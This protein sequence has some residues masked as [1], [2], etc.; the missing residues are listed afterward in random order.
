[1]GLISRVSSRTY[2]LD[3]MTSK[4]IFSDK[5]SI[6][7]EFVNLFSPNNFLIPR[8]YEGCVENILIPSGLIKDR[9]ER[10]ASDY[11]N[12]LSEEDRKKPILAM[13]VLKGANQ[14]FNDLIQELKN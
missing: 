8:H 6:K 2:R 4:Q 7:P 13:C 5:I 10:M 14:Y 9:V 12:S 11:Y 1:M 3:K